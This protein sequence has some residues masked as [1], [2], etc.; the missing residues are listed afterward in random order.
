MKRNVLLVSLL[1][2]FCTSVVLAQPVEP[3]SPPAPV[4][5]VQPATPSIVVVPPASQ[6]TVPVAVP[7]T[8]AEA[9]EQAKTAIELAK[10]KNWFG[11]SAACIFIIMFVLNATKLFDKIGKRWAYIILPVLGVTA[12]FLSKF[13]GGASW[14]SALVV[15]TSAPCTGLLWDF[16]KKGILA[17]EPETPMKPVKPA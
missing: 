11:L 17:K 15:L 10:A 3:T 6:P 2:V 9:L 16:F 7:T 4:V 14:E 8:P 13:V 12:M 1:S 5:K